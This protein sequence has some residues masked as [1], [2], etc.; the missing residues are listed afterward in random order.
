MAVGGRAGGVIATLTSDLSLVAA[1]GWAGTVLACA[2]LGLREL[3][4][5]RRTIEEAKKPANS[6]NFVWPRV[7]SP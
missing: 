5:I 3:E 6:D 4:R 2:V 1:G 7:D